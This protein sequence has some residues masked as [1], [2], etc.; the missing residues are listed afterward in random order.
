[1]FARVSVLL[2]V[3]PYLV[4]AT[5]V[6]RGGGPTVNQCDTGSIKC[7][8]SVQDVCISMHSMKLGLTRTRPVVRQSALSLG[9]WGLFYLHSKG[10]SGVSDL[11]CSTNP[12]GIT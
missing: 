9:F 6:R 4:A 12:T 8:N 1:M 11:I 3:V 2:L 5:A 7:C 10:K